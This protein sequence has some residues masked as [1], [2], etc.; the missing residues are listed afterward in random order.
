MI[1]VCDINDELSNKV[2]K[3]L[4][5]KPFNNMDDFF[6]VKDIDL[7]FVLTS[8]G[9]HYPHTKIAL[10]Y[11]KH[12]ITEKPISLKLDE[13]YE[14][15]KLADRKNL[16]S[17]V[18]YQNRYNPSIKFLQD[19]IKNNILGKRVLSTV[20]LR[21]CR[22]P[23]YYNNSWHGSWEMDGGVI[24]QQAIHHLDI[25]QWLGGEIKSVSGTFTQ[26]LNQLE[27]DDTTVAI[28]EF[29]DGSLGA[30]EATTSARPKD[31][32]ASF[33]IIAENGLVEIGG[34]AL[35]QIT[36]WNIIKE[37][38][39]K[40]IIDKYSQ[41]VKDG[42]GLGH[43]PFIQDV[44]DRLNKGNTIAPI[45]IEEGIKSLKLVHAIY[46]SAESRS[47]INM[48]EDLQSDFLGLKN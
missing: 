6:K 4:N 39:E 7:V 18:V 31:Y 29:L 2:A 40:E 15:S 16:M 14:L 35:N 37:K 23:E 34:V 10:S 32:E 47:W 48:N 8:S 46:K 21:W 1:A 30:I 27:A 19:Q 36:K 38:N 33:S 9:L 25:L 12:V 42:F 28:V 44:I 13:A 17:G 5:A 41:N 3:K 45:S 20:R 24:A 22:Y 11:N 43:G 26:R